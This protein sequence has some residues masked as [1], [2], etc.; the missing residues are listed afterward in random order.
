MKDIKKS[1][2]LSKIINSFWNEIFKANFGKIKYERRV[3]ISIL[4]F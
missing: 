2:S 3:K 1:A 4:M